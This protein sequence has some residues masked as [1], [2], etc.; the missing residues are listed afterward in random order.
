MNGLL[1][2]ITGASSGIG[3]ASAKLLAK[4]GAEV[5][6]GAGLFIKSPSVFKLQYMSGGKP[7]PYLNRFKICALQGLSLNF[8]GSGTYATYSDGT[9]VNMNLSL[10]FQ[11]LTPIYFEDYGSAEGKTGVGY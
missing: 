10:N 3:E 8:T 9:P 6:G 2:L 11:E 5:G 1:I 7:H 4:K